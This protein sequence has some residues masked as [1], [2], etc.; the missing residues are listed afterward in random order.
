MGSA[1]ISERQQ[2]EAWGWGQSRKMQGHFLSVFS[3]NDAGSGRHEGRNMKEKMDWL[4]VLGLIK[5]RE[6]ERVSS[7]GSLFL[8]RVSKQTHKANLWWSIILKLQSGFEGTIRSFSGFYWNPG[9][10]QE[11][12]IPPKC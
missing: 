12:N 10:S 3:H 2:P 1:V 5:S 7:D 4:M 11:W 6:R 9:G 8:T